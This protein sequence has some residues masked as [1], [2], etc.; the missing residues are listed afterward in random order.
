MQSSTSSSSFYLFYRHFWF[1]IIS[2]P[3]AAANTS[4]FH[5]DLFYYEIAISLRCIPDIHELKRT[6][7]AVPTL[8]LCVNEV[9]NLKTIDSFGFEVEK[10]ILC[11]NRLVCS[12]GVLFEINLSTWIISISTLFS[13]IL[14]MIWV[15]PVSMLP[16]IMPTTQVSS[17]GDGL[18]QFKHHFLKI[19]QCRH[20]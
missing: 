5:L 15:L 2:A 6:F 12:Q 8:P 11:N 9:G 20:K 10:R 13:E 1:F 14:N 4:I 3:S 7:W 18:G 16:L 17:L 19:I